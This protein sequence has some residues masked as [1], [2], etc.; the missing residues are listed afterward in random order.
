MTETS[1]AFSIVL[2]TRNRRRLLERAVASVLSQSYQNFELIIVDDA[3]TD[4][5]PQ[6]VSGISDSRI[7]PVSFDKQQGVSAARNAGIATACGHYVT[8]LDDDDEMLPSFLER[9]AGHLQGTSERVGFSWCGVQKVDDLTGNV[10]EEVTWRKPKLGWSDEYLGIG[11]GFG[12]TVKAVCFERVGVFDEALPTSVDFDMLIRLGQA[13]DFVVV[14]DVLVVVHIHSGPRLTDASRTRLEA[15]ERISRKHRK[16]F[17]RHRRAGF[18]FRQKT[19]F[20]SDRLGQRRKSRRLHVQNLL[21]R[22]WNLAAWRSYIGFETRPFRR[23][24]GRTTQGCEPN[25]HEP[26][27]EDPGNHE[28]DPLVSVV[29]PVYN[30]RATLKRTLQSVLRQSYRHF[31]V[32]IV[33][34]GSYDRPGEVVVELGDSRL[35]FLQQSHRGAAA[36]RNRGAAEAHGKWLAFLDGDDLVQVEWLDALI[37]RASAPS[38]GVVCCGVRIEDRQGNIHIE[39]PS[40]R[41]PEMRGF[42]CLFLAGTFIV[43][44][45]LFQDVNGYWEKLTYSENTELGLRLTA[46]CHEHGLRVE[47]V[48]EP[49]MTYRQDRP[50]GPTREQLL[51]RLRSSELLL[52]RH[53]ETLLTSPRFCGDLLA[54][55]AVRAARL[56]DYSQARRFLYRAVRS[57]PKGLRNW[58][59]LFLATVPFLGRRVWRQVNRS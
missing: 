27:Q 26:S 57:H 18:R 46:F 24:P 1:T 9:T 14:P 44:R 17:R 49:L 33:D 40:R 6:Y 58:S 34:D 47:S 59:R 43:R 55:A 19:A 37:R 30:E 29:V 42:T 11:S 21:T 3:S 5:T 23:G 12:L 8:F 36:A 56:D 53:R 39:E 45:S 7:V 28:R 41:G 20:L 22:P 32:L 52:K 10:V 51:S 31:E 54:T 13:Y 35:R 15:Y 48:R 38:V 4:A 2:P 50:S 25:S 16:F